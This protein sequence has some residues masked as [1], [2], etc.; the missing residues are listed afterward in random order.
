[1]KTKL[2][3]YLI[4]CLDENKISK[5]QFYEL[6]KKHELLGLFEKFTKKWKNY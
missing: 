2:L 6:L 5:K 4:E 1:M 3:N